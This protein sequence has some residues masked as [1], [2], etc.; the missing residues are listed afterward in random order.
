MSAENAAK[1]R[2]KTVPLD[3]SQIEFRAFDLEELIDREHPARAIWELAGKFD[4]SRFEAEVKTVEGSAGRPCWPARLLV[5]VWVYSYTLGVASARAIARMVTHEPGLRWLTADQEINYHT[6][7]DF[8]VGHK[9]ALENLFAQLL[10]GLQS[11]G[12]VDFR[13]LLHD[14]TKV[15]AVAGSGSLHRRKT[16]EQQLKEARRVVKK[17]DQQA[18]E[19]GEGMDA[20]QRAAKER[21]AR[22]KLKRAEAAVEKLQKLEAKTE[23]SQQKELRV[24]DSEPEA[25]RMKQGDG[26]IAPSYN[27]Q[28]TT[29]AKSRMVVA[30]AVTTSCNDVEELVP[31]VEQVQQSGIQPERVIAD[32]GYATRQNVE[33]MT[34]AGIE[35]ISPWKEDQSRSA[36][37]CKRNGIA[38]EFAPG[39]FVP[40]RGG[41]KLRCPAGKDLVWIQQ[42][43]HHG[44]KKN[45]F[46]ASARDC[47]RCKHVEA[48]CGKRGGPRRVERVVESAA[49]KQYLARMKRPETKALY[50]KRSE[51]AEFP[52]MWMK[53]VKGWRRFSVRGVAKAGSEA[54]WMA[55]TY[56]ISQWLRLQPQAAA[57]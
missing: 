25:R 56:N 27:V 33:E 39:E 32:T 15:K 54:M 29:E 46:E 36:G 4:L 50:R 11:G 28:V 48:C 24:S 57:A 38:V 2:I 30:I 5:S 3:R 55:L 49:M 20:R 34:K 6:L 1:P 10:A 51:I 40:Q 35:M 23:P 42:K 7:A 47:K 9:E 52:H 16:L 8:R 41:K 43:M 22:D 14:G 19:D 21:A 45:V 37:A 13:T 17:L 18:A 26:G 12:L 31:A 44:E 53:A